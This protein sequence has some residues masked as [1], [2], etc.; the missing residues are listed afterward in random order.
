MRYFSPLHAPI[1]APRACF[2]VARAVPPRVE[3]WSPALDVMT[4]F[5]SVRAVTV[6]P[7]ASIDDA[8]RTMIKNG[9]RLL[10]VVASDELIAGVITATDVLG[11]K[12]MQI[13]QQR[14][15]KHSEIEVCHIMTPKEMLETIE[16]R[17]ALDAKVGHI[18]ATLKRAHRQHAIVVERAMSDG[19]YAVRGLF[20]ASQIARQL[21]V[22]V[23]VGDVARTFAEIEMLLNN[24]D[25]TRDLWPGR[26][27]EAVRARS[28]DDSAAKIS[29]SS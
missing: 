4:D 12:P 23:H 16:M 20:S 28:R 5:D 11:E 2:R 17:E 19:C 21:G 8:N 14:G 13:V 29:F 22:P 3:L 26:T 25:A 24:G 9:V 15:V 10:L 1:V 6:D 18:V 7:R 27:I